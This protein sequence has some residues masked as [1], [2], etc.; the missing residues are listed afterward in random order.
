MGHGRGTLG[1]EEIIQTEMKV[2]IVRNTVKNQRMR[3]D[4]ASPRKKPLPW[5]CTA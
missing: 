3:E 5:E 1:L 4:R 2:K